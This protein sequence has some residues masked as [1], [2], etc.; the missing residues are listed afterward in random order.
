MLPSDSCILLFIL[1]LLP[2]MYRVFLC[3]QWN[4]VDVMGVA[5]S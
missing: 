4:M 3:D 5:K 1:L 2:H